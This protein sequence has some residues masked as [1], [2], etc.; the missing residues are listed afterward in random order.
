MEA[1]DRLKYV[2]ENLGVSE[3]TIADAI[4]E[5]EKL[6]ADYTSDT[7]KAPKLDEILDSLDRVN[8]IV[9]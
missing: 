8:I 4:R 7:I 1:I 3:E 5:A 9:R 2:L 6:I